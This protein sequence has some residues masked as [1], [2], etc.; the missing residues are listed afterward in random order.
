M[1]ADTSL[2]MVPH[3]RRVLQAAGASGL[4]ALAGCT[5][6]NLLDSNTEPTTYTLRV[7]P[8][9]RSPVEHELYEPDDSALFGTPARTALDD[10]LPDGQHTTYGYTPLPDD[11]YVAHQTHYYQVVNTVT[12][13]NHQPRT[14][15]RVSPV[16]EA[17]V[18]AAA[19][20]L[21]ALPRPS[22]RVLKILHSHTRSNGE[23]AT[24]LLH[25][26]A[27][28]LRRP[29]EQDSRLASGDLDGRV[30]TMTGEGVWAYRIHVTQE[31]IL[32]T[33]YTA[34]AIEVAA[35]RAAF[36]EIVFSTLIDAELSPPALAS[37]ARTIL[38][39]AIGRETYSESTPLSD[40]FD[41]LLAELNLAGVTES[42]NGRHLWYDGDFY[43]Y[44]L[45][46]DDAP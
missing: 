1:E 28:V 5:T 45:F 34:Q 10:I 41:A 4:A 6:A 24:D 12:G 7:Y 42:L 18:P 15:V 46:V 27:Y 40:A 17:Q 3:R 14:L 13:R 39:Q 19:L 22:A 35:S 38:E 21:D 44:A 11:G 31:P 2:Y 23:S 16:P 33:A 25:G 37:D 43:R 32:E 36:R 29:A 8:H 26:D 30:V 9:E 20:Q